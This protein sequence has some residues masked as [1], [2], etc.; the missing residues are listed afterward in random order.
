MGGLKP[1]VVCQAFYYG[2]FF[3]GVFTWVLQQGLENCTKLE[4]LSLDDNC[5]SRLDGLGKLTRLRRLSLAHNQLTSLDTGTLAFLPHL[6]YLAVDDNHLT[7]LAGLQQ[8]QSL[9]ELYI[10]NNIITNIREIFL[11]KV[12][13][14][15]VLLCSFVC[16]KLRSSSIRN[17][18]L[19]F[20]GV[21]FI[22][23]FIQF[24][25]VILLW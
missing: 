18:Y 1:V 20:F 13:L 17:K 16:V 4:D 3:V 8:A 22:N 19:S 9:V 14:V 11:L 21:F 24:Q 12:W 2:V 5:I 25:I 7:S 6:I 15:S 23:L 10:G